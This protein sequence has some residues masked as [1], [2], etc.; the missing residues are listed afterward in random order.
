MKWKDIMSKAPNGVIAVCVTVFACVVVLTLGA[1]AWKTG[2]PTELRSLLNTLFNLAT[3]LLTGTATV[4]AGAAA[5]SSEQAAKQ[6]NGD[7]DR[8]IESAIN[9]A[10]HPESPSPSVKPATDGE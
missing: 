7:L 6:T 10:L 2:D 4:V 3:L 5:R 9:R 1:F 8:R